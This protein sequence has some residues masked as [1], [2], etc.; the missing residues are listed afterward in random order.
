MTKNFLYKLT[1]RRSGSVWIFDDPSRGIVNEPFVAGMPEIIDEF[2]G[3][4]GLIDVLFAPAKFPG[5]NMHL[6][7][8]EDDCGGA[9][10]RLDSTGMTGWLCPVLLQYMSPAPEDIY[11]QVMQI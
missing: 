11:T 4:S 9:T 3:G 2:A 10:Y 5:A 1:L 6:I 7:K 8:L